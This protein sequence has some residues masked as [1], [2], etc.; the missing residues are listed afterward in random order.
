MTDCN[1]S[2]QRYGRFFAVYEGKVLVCVCLYKKGAI[3][4]IQRL[5]QAL[6]TSPTSQAQS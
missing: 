5:L 6:A 3:A 1:L 2:I 4:V